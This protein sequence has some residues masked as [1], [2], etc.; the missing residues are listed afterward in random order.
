MKML[1]G[2]ESPLSI[3]LTTSILIAAALAFLAGPAAADLIDP[4]SQSRSV[5][6]DALADGIPDSESASAVA[7]ELFDASVDADVF[8]PDSSAGASAYQRSQIGTDS[9]T[10][11]G[12]VSASATG[13]MADATSDSDFDFSFTIRHSVDHAFSAS[14]IPDIGFGTAAVWLLDVSRDETLAEVQSGGQTE[15]MVMGL[16]DPGEHRILA[17][18]SAFDMGDLGFGGNATFNFSLT[19]VPEPSAALL[20]LSAIATLGALG[21]ARSRSG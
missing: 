4:I 19:V 15:V 8:G 13:L 21:L 6:A 5:R 2:M 17:F 11:Q 18:A 10:G 3:A 7:F 12:D 9:V 1:R 14:V 16:L 20:Q